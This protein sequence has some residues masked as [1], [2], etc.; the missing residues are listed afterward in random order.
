VPWGAVVGELGTALCFGVLGLFLPLG[1]WMTW[2]DAL[3]NWHFAFI[4][5][6]GFL[7]AVM[8]LQRRPASL[9][10][11]AV[12]AAYIGLPSLLTLWQALSSVHSSAEALSYVMLGLGMLGQVA[13][14]WSC[15][16]RLAPPQ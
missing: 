2:P 13:V 16:T 14:L 15:L 10:A 6:V 11:A 3:F 9:K 7:L 5:V 12:L 8:L 1:H 4:V